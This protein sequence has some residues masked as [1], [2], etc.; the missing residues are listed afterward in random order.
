MLE[1]W[2]IMIRVKTNIPDIQI[3]RKFV[4]E[5]LEIQNIKIQGLKTKLPFLN[6]ESKKWTTC[7]ILKD[8]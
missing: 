3:L 2:T 5:E 8:A 1:Y 7:M 4:R 6:K